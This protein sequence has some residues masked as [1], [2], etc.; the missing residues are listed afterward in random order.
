MGST[1][2]TLTLGAWWVTLH[3]NPRKL[4][5]SIIV[6]KKYKPYT[7]PHAHVCARLNQFDD[8]C[9]KGIIPTDFKSKTE[10]AESL[11]G[12]ERVFALN[13]IKEQ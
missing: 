3:L 10:Y 8:D 2:H 9:D 1:Y 12:D 7:G 5:P 11:E 13:W 6:P 4:F